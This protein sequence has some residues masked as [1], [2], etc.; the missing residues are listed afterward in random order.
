M[1][2]QTAALNIGGEPNNTQEYDGTGWIVGVTA[3]QSQKSGGGAGTQAS[4]LMFGD[5]GKSTL[6]QEYEGS[7]TTAFRSG[8]TKDIS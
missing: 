5:Q 7:I 8:G 6:T 1:G 2:T 3:P 4:A